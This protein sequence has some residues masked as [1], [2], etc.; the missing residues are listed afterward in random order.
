[1]NAPWVLPHTI[2]SEATS[3]KV[4]PILQIKVPA[5]A[6][7]RHAYFVRLLEMST[8]AI[9]RPAEIVLVEGLNQTQ[10]WAEMLT[11]GID[12]LWGG[13]TETRDQTFRR[14]D[15]RATNGLACMRVIM[16]KRGREAEFADI[17]SIEDL[18]AR[19]KVCGV[20]EAWFEHALW[21][22]NDLPIFVLGGNWNDLFQMLKDGDPRIDYITR[23]VNE[24]AADL[25]HNPELVAESN[26][27]IVHNR[28]MRFY[29]TPAAAQL[30]SL[31]EAALME[32]DQSGLKKSLIAEY[33]HPLSETLNLQART[34][35]RMATPGG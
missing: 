7:N 9:G 2:R 12:V 21:Q 23:S 28:D 29:L 6:N 35:L 5:L 33:L 31:L 13:R 24:A 34:R 17:H 22:G 1:M 11:G 3:I 20:G 32:A 27:L 10:M 8:A 15:V 18:R 4:S 19:N 26:L 14:I 30:Q 25:I 16:V